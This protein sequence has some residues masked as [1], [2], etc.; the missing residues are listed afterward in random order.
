[1][2]TIQAGDRMPAVT[3]HMM[4]EGGIK[5]ITTDELF[6]GKTVVLFSV[7]G[8]FTPTCS[9]QHLPGFVA[10][11]DDFA[12]KGVDAVACV[13]VN[14]PFVMA[15]WGASAGADGQVLMISDGNGALAAATGT[16]MDGSQVGL[17]TRS[18]RYAMVVKDGVV[19]QMFLEEPG[20]FQVSSAENVLAHL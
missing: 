1:M 10:H 7:P 2:S 6:A 17:G 8:A 19:E 9:A 11:V 3:L 14:D 20:A 18:Q 15:T 12:A 5:P 13:A 16:E 4:S